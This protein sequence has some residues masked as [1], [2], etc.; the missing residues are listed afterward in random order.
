MALGE[1]IS[2]RFDRF[3]VIVKLFSFKLNHKTIFNSDFAPGEL[4]VGLAFFLYLEMFV[5]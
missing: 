3:Y 1:F 5:F 2:F 4:R